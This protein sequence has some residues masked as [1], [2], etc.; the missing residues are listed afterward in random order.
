M[1]SGY[2]ACSFDLLNVADLDVIGQARRRCDRLVVGVYTDEYAERAS[3]RP[4]VV[5]LSERVEILRHVRGV[6]QVLE[7][8]GSDQEAIRRSQLVFTVGD[9]DL[10]ESPSGTILLRPTRT[11][12]SRELRDALAPAVQTGVA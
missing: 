6:D 10:P 8:D 11:T 9:V 12:R 5:P 4:P 1:T 7:H 2:L 3:G